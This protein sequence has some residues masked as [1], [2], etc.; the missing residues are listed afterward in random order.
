MTQADSPESPLSAA[1]DAVG[2]A[3]EAFELLSSETRLAILVALWDAYDPFDDENAVGFT[4]L[5]R[6]VGMTDSGQFN[7]HL[8]KLTGHFVES[9]AEGYELREP[10]RKF[11]RA[12]IAGA[13]I[14]EPTMDRTE[15][16]MDCTLCGGDVEV[17][18]EDGWVYNVCTDC[19]GLWDDEEAPTGHLS[20]FQFDPAGF[21]HRSADEV[22]AAAWVRAFQHIYSMIEGVCPTCSGS[23]DRSLDT[24]SDHD[25]SGVCEACG[26]RT[27]LTV[28]FRCPVCKDWARGTMGVVAKY[29]PAAVAFYYDHGLTLQ[30]GFN[31]V[32]SINDRLE[33]G[34]TSSEV[35][36]EDPLTVR[37]TLALDGDELA[38]DLAE[39]LTVLDVHEP[40]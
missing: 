25:E 19:D 31:D 2:T 28:R 40:A 16:D 7:Y 23:V 39:D 21:A 9:A 22:Y 10:G 5:R 1:S 13:G 32:A 36:S 3:A 12:V 38:L 20:K 18:Y 24:C 4:D 29:H 26:R 15:I 27:A 14:E 17:F 11:V 35:L 37:V 34:V 6:T 33:R 30:Y 8:E